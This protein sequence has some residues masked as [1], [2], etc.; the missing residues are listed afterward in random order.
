MNISGTKG[1]LSMTDFVVPFAGSEL[2]FESRTPVSRN[3]GCEV[4]FE[5]NTRHWAV[6]EYS[7]GHPNAQETNLFRH[8]AAQVRS[9]SLNPVWP[10][11]ALK[12]QQV[13][14][15]CLDSARAGRRMVEVG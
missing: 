4:I 13:L 2:A 12:T 5:P 14:Q 1:N 3:Q 10:E 9:G 6:D 8:F 15:A 7:H 11:I